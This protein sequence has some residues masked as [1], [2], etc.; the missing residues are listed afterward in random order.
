MFVFGQDI[1]IDLG[2]AN[3]KMYLDA[4][5]A[6]SNTVKY[7]TTRAFKNLSNDEKVK[8]LTIRFYQYAKNLELSDDLNDRKSIIKK[9]KSLSIQYMMIFMYTIILLF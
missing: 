1:A 4:F 3:F 9:I 6:D 2:T 5:E 7:K 8:Q